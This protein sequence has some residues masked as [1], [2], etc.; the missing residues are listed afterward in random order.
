MLAAGYLVAR[1][2]GSRSDGNKQQTASATS[3]T[4]TGARPTTTSPSAAYPNTSERQLLQHIAAAM[5]ASCERAP[6]PLTG[7]I[8]AVHCFGNNLPPVQYNLFRSKTVMARLLNSRAKAAG[9]HT[10]SC[11]TSR[12]HEKHVDKA[13]HQERQVGR[14]LC[15]TIRGEARLEWTNERLKIYTFSFS[16]RMSTH[17]M[18][19]DVYV[20]AGPHPMRHGG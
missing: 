19:H 15:Y 8:A 20:P 16:R 13:M 5:R 6:K 14:L 3:S 11:K 1:Q 10:G 4:S 9:A 7:A 2:T 18:Y 12:P 17:S